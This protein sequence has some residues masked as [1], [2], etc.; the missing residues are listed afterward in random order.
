MYRKWTKLYTMTKYVSTW[1]D[2]EVLCLIPSD[3]ER[4][5]AEVPADLLE[6]FQTTRAR[7]RELG[8]QIADITDA[9]RLAEDARRAALT[10][11]QRRDEDY[12]GAIAKFQE[13][14]SA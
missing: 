14:L 11:K 10:P 1:H 7:L 9:P 6:E 3:G 4:F 5:G 12:A 13:R 8:E 2:E